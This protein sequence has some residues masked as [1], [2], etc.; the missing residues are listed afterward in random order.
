[1]HAIHANRSVFTAEIPAL[2]DVSV[3]W[4]K[5]EIHEAFSAEDKH[6]LIA[7]LPD[8]CDPKRILDQPFQVSWDADTGPQ[9]YHGVIT[10]VELSADS[11]GFTMFTLNAG[12]PLAPLSRIRHSR[13]FTDQTLRSIL[14]ALIRESRLVILDL[15]FHLSGPDPLR[16]FTAQ[17]GESDRA[18]ME[19][20]LHE[21]G[22]VYW[23]VHQERGVV[24]H[25]ADQGQ[26]FPEFEKLPGEDRLYSVQRTMGAGGESISALSGDFG[27]RPGK[28]ITLQGR[29]YRLIAV[30][31]VFDEGNP[32]D[33][34]HH[35]CLMI[36]RQQ[37]I[38]PVYEA[39]GLINTLDLATV[40]GDEGA[41]RLTE[42]GEY[43]LQFPD[44][45][46]LTAPVR[47]ATPFAG[48]DQG[49]HCPLHDRSQVLVAYLQGHPDR[50]VLLGAL[51]TEEQPSLVT[52]ENHRQN[53][54]LTAAGNA[55]LMDDSPGAEKIHL[56]TPDL[57][58]SLLLDASEA[59]PKIALVAER[60]EFEGKIAGNVQL[61]SE[62]EF[63][64]R[65]GESM[66]LRARDDLQ[67]SAGEDLRVQVKNDLSFQ[68]EGHVE[69]RVNQSMHTEI[70][71]GDYALQVQGGNIHHKAQ[72]SLFFTAE[73]GDIQL[74]TAQASLTLKADGSIILAGKSI[75]LE[76]PTI[77]MD[78][79]AEVGD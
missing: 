78:N 67:L 47:L 30:T 49:L 7:R 8:Q 19:R 6:T 51:F 50:P 42:Q 13:H 74:K 75:R 68:V 12:S 64:M 58:Q 52:A 56:H 41:P 29:D 73:H 37:S 44:R 39:Q 77:D 38:R 71:N 34:Y 45:D 72:Q 61:S 16:P 10:G 76:A 11:P 5:L 21:S 59:G 65:A 28:W 2:S 66:T 60:G 57:A 1:M 15:Q 36:P 4:V 79:A 26:S 62:G 46:N 18:F 55:L 24:L 9:Y 3:N 69:I 43:Y 54:W 33:R 40:Q 20:L 27:A 70:L 17:Q 14:T 31:H 53:R 35:R 63:E 22:W 23:L 48:A 25:L 32:K